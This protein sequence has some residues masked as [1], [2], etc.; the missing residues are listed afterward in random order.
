DVWLAGAPS[1]NP[2][3]NH[4]HVNCKVEDYLGYYANSM[5]S[6]NATLLSLMAGDSQHAKWVTAERSVYALNIGF[7]IAALLATMLAGF[8]NCA[9]KR[10]EACY[11]RMC[12]CCCCR[13]STGVGKT[14]PLPRREWSL[15]PTE[16]TTWW[17]MVGWKVLGLCFV[18][19][20]QS[21]HHCSR[22]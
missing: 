15:W 12:V 18:E 3:Y 17:P 16:Y 1:K 6:Y 7:V 2:T 22:S 20:N 9:S 13:R 5:K 10:L 14:A 21:V 4:S 8:C 11:E 19:V